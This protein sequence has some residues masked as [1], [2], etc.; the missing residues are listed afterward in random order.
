MYRRVYEFSSSVPSI[1]FFLYIIPSLRSLIYATK[2][3]EEVVHIYYPEN[4]KARKVELLFL[5][6]YGPKFIYFNISQQPPN[7][8]KNYGMTTEAGAFEKKYL[9]LES[10]KTLFLIGY[11]LRDTSSV[12]LGRSS[13]I[14]ESFIH[15]LLSVFMK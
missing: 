7:R 13:I 4:E 1:F 2:A 11:I 6:R 9:N 3:Y 12:K 10:Y 8:I 5:Q 15:S 14:H